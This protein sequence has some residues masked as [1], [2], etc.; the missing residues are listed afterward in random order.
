MSHFQQLRLYGAVPDWLWLP[1][2]SE[3]CT[4]APAGED[5]EQDP[6]TIWTIADSADGGRC[7]Q[8]D[9]S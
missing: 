9:F 8:P 3:Y 7:E 5:I 2:Y 1:L 6:S 4:H